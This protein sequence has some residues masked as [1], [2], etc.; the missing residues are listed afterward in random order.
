MITKKETK[1][2]EINKISEER[3]GLLTACECTKE[4]WITLVRIK[5]ILMRLN[6]TLICWYFFSVLSFSYISSLLLLLIGT[7]VNIE[8]QNTDC[9]NSYL[10]FNRTK[11]SVT[12]W[13]FF[14]FS[15]RLFVHRREWAMIERF[16]RDWLG[17]KWL[18]FHKKKFIRNCIQL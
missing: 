4:L 10:A 3:F 12:K 18:N 5:S 13:L 15:R 6:F 14:S 17:G 1:R 16:N 8:S 9:W 11:P 2:N 7:F